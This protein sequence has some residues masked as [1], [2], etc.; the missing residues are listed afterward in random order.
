MRRSPPL[1]PAL[2][3]ISL[4]SLAGAPSGPREA[5][6][7]DCKEPQVPKEAAKVFD[8]VT[9]AFRKADASAVMSYIAPGD[10]GSVLLSLDGVPTAS[11]SR[12]HGT[13]VLAKEYFAKKTIA[14]LKPGEECTS[15]D[16]SKL[17]RVYLLTLKNGEKETT[18]SLTVSIALRPAGDKAETYAWVLTSVKER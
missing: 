15:G 8:G 13:E 7:K 5:E 16:E 14:A 18:V 3:A 1:I 9:S 6:A 4:A 12:E 10:G 11:Y 2:L 17:S